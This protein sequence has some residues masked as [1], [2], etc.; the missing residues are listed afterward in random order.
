[1]A[2][3]SVGGAVIDRPEGDDWVSHSI[4]P[5]ETEDRF[6]HA[7][8]LTRAPEIDCI[9][10]LVAP[11]ILAIAE[12]RAIEADIGAERVLITWGVISEETYV[13][14]LATHLGIP[15]EPL[16]HT[17]RRHCPLADHQLVEAANTGMLPLMRRDGIC[18]GAAAR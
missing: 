11:A 14:A 8:H 1:M 17:S 2:Y 15:F 12:Q 6:A 4:A 7:T 9:R 13:A 10:H 3:S 5:L 18:R 16:S